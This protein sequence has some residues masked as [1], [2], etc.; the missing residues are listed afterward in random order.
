ME[1]GLKGLVICVLGGD[2]REVE[3]IR[4]FLGEGALVRVV[5][6]PPLDELEGTTRETS[7]FQGIH[8]ASA[9]VVGMG[10]LD[11][12][13]KVRTLD[14]EINIALTEELLELIPP[15]VPL[16][17]GAARPR[18]REFASKHNVNLVEVTEDDEI[19]IRNSIPTA[20]GA[21]QIAMEE[22]PITIHGCNAVVVGFGRVGETMA[23]VLLSLC[24][25]T[26]VCARNLAQLARASE[27]GASTLHISSLAMALSNADV[28]F[29]TV[30]AIVLTEKTLESM[31]PGSLI[32][33][34]ASAP[35]GTD[36]EAATRLGIKAILAPGLP[37]K[38]APKTAGKILADSIP[39]LIRRELSR[40]R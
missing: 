30:P 2:F 1:E 15:G 4:K 18:L 29:N 5:G 6:Y 32:I 21:L 12:G 13:G 14:P 28:V 26:V 36:F 24:A 27:M 34:L 31:S 10:G 16:L 38:V 22:M 9:I 19:A 40:L 8:G 11:V 35:G 39:Q 33:D 3:L 23:R 17:V 25:N 37:G 20:E 7:V